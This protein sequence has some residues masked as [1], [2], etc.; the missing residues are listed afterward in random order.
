MNRALRI[1]LSAVGLAALACGGA[2]EPVVEEA[3]DTAAIAARLA[4][5]AGGWSGEIRV[6]ECL[7]DPTLCLVLLV[8]N[9]RVL[10]TITY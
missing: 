7:E 3:P 10:Y 8:G 6:F 5:E 2:V 9:G 1:I 4:A